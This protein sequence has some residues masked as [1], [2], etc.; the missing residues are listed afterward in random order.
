MPDRYV[1]WSL[2]ELTPGEPMPVPCYMY[3]GHRFIL[4]R[5]RGDLI[6]RTTY[7]RMDMKAVGNIFIRRSDEAAMEAWVKSCR[8]IQEQDLPISRELHGARQEAHR[9]MMDIFHATH[10][11]EIV[12]KT[13]KT[14]EKLV[15][16]LMKFPFAAKPLAQLQTYSRGTVDHSVNVSVLSVFLAMNLGYTH[17]LILRHIAAGA[18]LHDL[19]KA[20]LQIGDNELPQDVEEKLKKHPAAAL[21][22][23]GADDSISKEVKM[24]VAQ[25]HECNDGSG[26]PKGM[27]GKSIYDLAKIVSIANE[28][29]GLVSGSR[30][31]LDER[32]QYAIE[33]L[34][35]PLAHKF[36]PSKLQKALKVLKIGI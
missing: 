6:D 5:N 29:D 36:D 19:G 32:Q 34:A 10:P 27:F 20:K 30:G 23:L 21:E 8:N 15:T 28:F 33:Q 1:S 25:H 24:I 22:Y 17:V 4:F 31:S 16:E 13:L 11:N 7:D 18:L 9:S 2:E 26:Y 12:T 3:L 14:S 35:G